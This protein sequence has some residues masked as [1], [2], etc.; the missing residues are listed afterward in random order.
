MT[1]SRLTGSKNDESNAA[2]TRGVPTMTLK[3][4][5]TEQTTA[6]LKETNSTVVPW[7]GGIPPKKLEDL[8]AALKGE[9]QPN[10]TGW[11]YVKEEDIKGDRS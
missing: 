5:V 9:P 4:S 10:G 2:K 3:E 1:P 8:K 7:N 11:E 6:A